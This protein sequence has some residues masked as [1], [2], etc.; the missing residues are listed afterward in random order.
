MRP[1]R[2][3]EPRLFEPPPAS[4]PELQCSVAVN[5][6]G[7]SGRATIWTTVT[8][9][10]TGN[11][12]ACWSSDDVAIS[13]LPGSALEVLADGIRTTLRDLSPF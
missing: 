8:D 12:I 9:L 5:I 6:S 4:Y 11:R 13:S 7:P 10:Q 1:P 3:T 2:W